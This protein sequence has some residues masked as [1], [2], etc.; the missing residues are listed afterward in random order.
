MNRSMVLSRM[1]AYS[2]G[3]VLVT[4]HFVPKYAAFFNLPVHNIWLYLAAGRPAAVGSIQ[5]AFVPKPA[6]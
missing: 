5:T 4:T 1:V 6:H 2:L 3:L